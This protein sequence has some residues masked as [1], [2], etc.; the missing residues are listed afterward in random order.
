[1]VHLGSQQSAA[2]SPDL[3]HMVH[4]SHLGPQQL[5]A[6][7]RL[8]EGE[9]GLFFLERLG[10]CAQNK[11]VPLETTVVGLGLRGDHHRGAH[12]ESRTGSAL[13]EGIYCI[14]GRPSPV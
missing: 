8:G 14:M 7:N 10:L 3:H 1:M 11:P 5:A 13:D 6:A 12:L 2:N 9:R 4:A